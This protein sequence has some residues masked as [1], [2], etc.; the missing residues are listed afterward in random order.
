MKTQEY[1]NIAKA[2]EENKGIKVS[3]IHTDWNGKES[4]HI[5]FI[6]N[7]AANECLIIRDITTHAYIIKHH[8]DVYFM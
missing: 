1:N 8:K 6:A 2:I 5:G 4:A 7:V 3:F